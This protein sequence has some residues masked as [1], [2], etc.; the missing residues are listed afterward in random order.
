MSATESDLKASAELIKFMWEVTG[1]DPSFFTPEVMAG[2]PALLAQNFAQLP[3]ELQL[4]F[5]NGQASNREIQQLWNQATPDVKLAMSVQFQQALSVLMFGSASTM[6]GSES[7][8]GE[9]QSL[10]ADIASNI[11]WNNSGAGDWSSR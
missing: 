11:A 7:G 8:S 5:A 4:V 9:S 2:I 1:N 3:P 10:N 6:T